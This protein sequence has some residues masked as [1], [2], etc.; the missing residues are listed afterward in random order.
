MR[1]KVLIGIVLTC[2]ILGVIPITTIAQ[3]SPPTEFEGQIEDK[4]II[5]F[6]TEGRY[7]IGLHNNLFYSEL[8]V[9]FDG[10]YQS[11]IPKG[12]TLKYFTVDHEITHVIVAEVSRDKGR[13]WHRYLSEE[14]WQEYYIQLKKSEIED[15][16]PEKEGKQVKGIIEIPFTYNVPDGLEWNAEIIYLDG[17]KIWYTL[18]TRDHSNPKV[19]LT[20]STTI[21]LATHL[22]ENGTHNITVELVDSEC[23]EEFCSFY[24]V[25]K[26]CRDTVSLDFQNTF[27]VP[28]NWEGKYSEPGIIPDF[29]PDFGVEELKKNYSSIYNSLINEWKYE[30]NEILGAEVEFVSAKEIGLKKIFDILN[31]GSDIKSGCGIYKT[32]RR[33]VGLAK[34]ASTIGWA[35][36]EKGVFIATDEF[37]KSTQPDEEIYFRYSEAPSGDL[38]GNK[39]VV[40]AM[41]KLEK[42]YCNAKI[43]WTGK[44]PFFLNEKGEWQFYFGNSYEIEDTKWDP[45]VDCIESREMTEEGE[46]KTF[47]LT[48]KDKV[49]PNLNDEAMH[50][51]LEIP[52]G[53][54]ISN[55]RVKGAEDKEAK[56]VKF[57]RFNEHPKN[58]CTLIR[59]SG[60]K[61]ETRVAINIPKVYQ[62]SEFEEFV[63]FDITV[64]EG[65]EG[66]QEPSKIFYGLI[67]AKVHDGGAVGKSGAWGLYTDSNP[68][69]VKQPKHDPDSDADKLYF[70]EPFELKH[71]FEITPSTLTVVEKGLEWLRDPDQ[72]KT[73]GDYV[74][75]TYKGTPNVGI[76]ALVT[77]AFL[78]QGYDESDPTVRGALNWLVAQANDDGSISRDT[79]KVYDTSL[80]ILPLVAAQNE[81][82]YGTVKAN[83]RNYL[84]SVQNNE[85]TG[86]DHSDRFYG[87]WGYPKDNWADLS[88]T[89]FVVM[90]LDASGGLTGGVKGNALTFV[91]RC[92]NREESNSE[93][94]SYDDGGFVYRPKSGGTSY[95][96]MTAAGLWGLFL[97]GVGKNDGRVQDAL[98]WLDERSV[99]ANTPIGNKWVYYYDLGLAKAYLM[100]EAR[101]CE[102]E[103][104]NWYEDLYAF[105]SDKQDKKDGHWHNIEGANSC[106]VLATAEAILA[107]S[108]KEVPE[109][110]SRLSYMVFKLRSAADLHIYDPEGRHVGLNSETGE[111]EIEIPDATYT[112]S[113]IEIKVP[114][115][116]AGGYKAVLI[117]TEAGEYE[118]EVIAKTGNKTLAEASYEG[119]I[120]EGTTQEMITTISSIVGPLDVRIGTLEAVVEAEDSYTE[121]FSLDA[122]DELE[123]DAID[124]TGVLLRIEAEEDCE[125]EVKIMYYSE[126][127]TIKGFPGEYKYCALEKYVELSLDVDR[128]KIDWPV[129]LEVHYD[130]DELPEN[131]DESTLTIYHY[132]NDTKWR[133]CNDFEVNPEE[134]YISAELE[135]DEL[136]Y[137]G[138]GGLYAPIW[139]RYS[140]ILALMA[141]VIVLALSYFSVRRFAKSRRVKA[142]KVPERV[143]AEVAITIYNFDNSFSLLNEREETAKIS[144]GLDGRLASGEIKEETYNALK[145]KYK[146]KIG[147]INRKIK[148][149]LERAKAYLQRVEDER[150]KL[151]RTHE[152]L[153]AE[154]QKETGRKKKAEI[155]AKVAEISAEI[156]RVDGII[157][158][159]KEKIGVIEVEVSGE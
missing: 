61:G 56:N 60:E 154:L 156:E 53:V 35:I 2:L 45:D 38:A 138:M 46:T 74:Y 116:E 139:E 3:P 122:G 20:S 51:D 84:I 131:V 125:G 103:K 14:D 44:F 25:E 87:G 129:Y 127:P 78:N 132:L 8:Y 128:E 99:S 11:T 24:V 52:K 102:F 130:K 104:T 89:Q 111:V 26:S 142:M 91:T 137:F 135:E 147:D 69:T 31:T 64:E 148:S 28:E 95:G 32:A 120:T 30:D 5:P 65:G 108:V 70:Y 158:T 117:G 114:N 58:K 146:S 17:K 109:R 63:L 140:M 42:D 123:V 157:K 67:P 27:V 37:Y 6:K 86:Y 79:R 134:N 4:D 126:N 10:D 40:Y 1:R 113:P 88:N 149:D 121:Q 100:A 66:Q 141:I 92:Q 36:L 9:F 152:P 7:E 18:D 41:T 21:K 94:C 107:L 15:I 136:C 155:S 133:S 77:L 150:T 81:A 143:P 151:Q 115:L 72:Q 112:E 57:Y 55:V 48:I 96:S 71:S 34:L 98:G 80:A 54:E 145:S 93:Y 144:D 106:D 49:I 59:T 13:A 159:M 105:L 153:N 68:I 97:C 16:D 29:H 43:K 85:G 119:W 76:T 12:P 47:N 90:A 39:Y 62:G 83:A 75:W 73:D 101:G 33:G 22:F 118:L 124:E 19:K 110:I 82:K 23:G 50:L